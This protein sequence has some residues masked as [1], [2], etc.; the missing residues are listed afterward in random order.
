M[1]QVRLVWRVRR[2]LG[3]IS[4][5]LDRWDIPVCAAFKVRRAILAD[6]LD[7]RDRLDRPRRRDRLDLRGRLDHRDP[8]EP[9][10]QQ[11]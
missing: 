9:R 3:E 8:R 10:V 5:Q 11:V 4:V 1:R 7:L 2:D 6:R